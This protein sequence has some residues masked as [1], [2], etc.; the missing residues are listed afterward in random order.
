MSAFGVT[1]LR[2][3]IKKLRAIR[4][5]EDE[6]TMDMLTVGE[7]IRQEAA[8]SIRQ[9]SVR[10]PGH[11]AS[12]PGQPPNADSGKL[13][14]SGEVRL[15]ATGKRAEVAF[16]APHAA[17]ME[18]GTVEVA[19]RPFLRPASQKHKCKLAILVVQSVNKAMRVH[20]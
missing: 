3:H 6:V 4:D 17:A 1:S 19:A 12:R 8:D 11:V 5:V 16:T 7:M 18:I 9:G 2:R 13:E 14:L 15:R 20:K 10:G